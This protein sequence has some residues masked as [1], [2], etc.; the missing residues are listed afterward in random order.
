SRHC[1]PFYSYQV[2]RAPGAIVQPGALRCRAGGLA[3]CVEAG[4][5]WGRCATATRRILFRHGIQVAQNAVEA[6]RRDMVGDLRDEDLRQ[7]TGREFLTDKERVASGDLL[8]FVRLRLR[9]L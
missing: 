9:G 2:R 3:D 5:G 7:L 6:R 8:T 1:L 4:L